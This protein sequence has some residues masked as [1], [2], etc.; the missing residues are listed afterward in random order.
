VLPEH[1]DQRI[2]VAEGYLHVNDGVCQGQLRL[3]RRAALHLLGQAASGVEGPAGLEEPLSEGLVEPFRDG[4][5]RALRQLGI[6]FRT[7]S[8]DAMERDADGRETWTYGRRVWACDLDWQP[9]PDQ[10]FRRV[11]A[12]QRMSRMLD[13][14]KP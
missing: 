9:G 7:G 11:A 4:A 12:R 3:G 1:R 10:K 8:G 6:R 14:R 13:Q 5:R 2:E